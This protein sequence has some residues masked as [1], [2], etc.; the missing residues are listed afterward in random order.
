MGAGKKNV[1]RLMNEE[2]VM[3]LKECCAIVKL[4]F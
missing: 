1:F 3:S 2:I 4:T